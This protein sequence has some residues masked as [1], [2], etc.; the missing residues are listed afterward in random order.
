MVYMV[1]R[2]RE[3]TRK[4]RLPTTTPGCV[5]SMHRTG[6]DPRADAT[7]G[8]R[9]R[10]WWWSSALVV[11][12]ARRHGRARVQ[13]GRRGRV[14]E[15]KDRTR[16]EEREDTGARRATRRRDRGMRRRWG[17][18]TGRMDDGDGRGGGGCEGGV[19]EGETGGR[20]RGFVARDG[21]GGW[22]TRVD[23]RLTSAGRGERRS[24]RI[25]CASSN[26]RRGDETVRLRSRWTRMR[27][28]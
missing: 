16:E 15:R 22:S 19:R 27:R 11:V 8:R 18:R 28:M 17:V 13:G 12:R 20:G 2:E 10:W 9:A 7:D 6:R 21:G 1:Y 14:G 26:A 4:G 5:W 3:R 25:W 23:A 24:R